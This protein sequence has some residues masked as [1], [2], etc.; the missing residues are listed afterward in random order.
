MLELDEAGKTTF[1][2]QMKLKK[3]VY[4]FLTIRFNVESVEFK[5][6]KSILWGI[7]W[8]LI[9][10]WY[11]Y[12]KRNNALTQIF[13]SK[14]AVRMK[15]TKQASKMVQK[16]SDMNGIPVLVQA[17]KQDIDLISLSEIQEILITYNLRNL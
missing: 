2:Y 15:D 14:Y 7:G 5:N 6:L 8:K 11:H 10:L 9:K 13:D 1:L 4:S 16:S 3:Q 12:F 17:N